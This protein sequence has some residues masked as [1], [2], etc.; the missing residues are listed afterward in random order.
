MDMLSSA[1]LHQGLAVVLNLA[2]RM[3]QHVLGKLK[4]RERA[5]QM[6]AVQLSVN[7]SSHRDRIGQR[8]VFKDEHRFRIHAHRAQCL[9][10]SL[11]HVQIQRLHTV[12]HDG[13]AFHVVLFVDF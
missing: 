2:A 10:M 9:V 6:S 11:A 3:A 1:V 5:V 13:R 7:E 8:R 4:S 12:V